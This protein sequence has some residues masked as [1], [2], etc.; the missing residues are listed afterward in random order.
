MTIDLDALANDLESVGWPLNPSSVPG[1]I[2]ASHNY[3]AG[4]LVEFT[5][6]AEG[7][8]TLMGYGD[9]GRY[10]ER[11]LIDA[12][13]DRAYRIIRKHLTAAGGDS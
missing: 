13:F 8:V 2:F 9:N 6:D 11:V 7:G 1:L 12:A 4:R 3:G 5:V 10:A